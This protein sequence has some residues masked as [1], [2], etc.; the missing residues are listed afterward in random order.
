MGMDR[1]G[2]EPTTSAMLILY[3]IHNI[4]EKEVLKE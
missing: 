4:E 2:F 3:R 1:V